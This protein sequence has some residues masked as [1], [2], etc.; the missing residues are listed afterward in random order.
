MA[1]TMKMYIK[2]HGLATVVNR[3]EEISKV[4]RIKTEAMC[5]N[6]LIR[7]C[8]K[9]ILTWNQTILS[10]YHPQIYKTIEKTNISK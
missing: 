6:I 5:E 2:N 10:T 9:Q 7:L 4:V 3:S 8:I 1:L